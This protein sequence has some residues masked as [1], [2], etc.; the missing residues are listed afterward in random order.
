MEERKRRY[1]ETGCILLYNSSKCARDVLL[2]AACFSRCVAHYPRSMIFVVC[3]Q[4]Y[5]W[6]VSL[7]PTSGLP[8]RSRVV[9]DVAFEGCLRQ[10]NGQVCRVGRFFFFRTIRYPPVSYEV[11]V[12]GAAPAELISFVTLV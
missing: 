12:K 3:Q 11:N 7:T 1:F 2:C 8:R 5:L 9:G 10:L 4:Q 6:L